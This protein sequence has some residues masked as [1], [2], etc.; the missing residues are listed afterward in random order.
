M[1]ICSLCKIAVASSADEPVETAVAAA[2]VAAKDASAPRGRAGA[3][4]KTKTRASQPSSSSCEACCAAARGAGL[5]RPPPARARYLG[6]SARIEPPTSRTDT[7]APKSR[8]CTR[9]MPTVGAAEPSGA[10]AGVPRDVPPAPD[11]QRQAALQA[12][13]PATVIEKDVRSPLPPFPPPP[14]LLLLLLLLLLPLLRGDKPRF[15]NAATVVLP[16]PVGPASK[17][18]TS[19]RAQSSPQVPETSVYIIVCAQAQ[20]TSILLWSN[21]VRIMRG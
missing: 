12:L 8:A 14:P 4:E 6:Q 19:G 7:S 2:K 16:P 20:P 18:R 15:S 17:M 10:N 9:F 3:S 21:V 5:C 1:R 13:L 11:K